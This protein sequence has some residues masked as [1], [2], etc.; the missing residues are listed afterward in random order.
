ME[1]RYEATSVRLTIMRRANEDNVK[2]LSLKP[3]SLRHLLTAIS[4]SAIRSGPISLK[5]LAAAIPSL[6]SVTISV[7]SLGHTKSKRRKTNNKQRKRNQSQ[8]SKDKEQRP[9]QYIK[10]RNYSKS[11]HHKKTKAHSAQVGI[12]RITMFT[13]EPTL[14]I[15]KF[16]QRC[17]CII[18]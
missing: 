16:P 2:L 15:T 7:N 17:P 3:P 6:V 1:V 11:T 9:R 13:V 14:N 5:T 10:R 12:C 8:R 18:Q 4:I